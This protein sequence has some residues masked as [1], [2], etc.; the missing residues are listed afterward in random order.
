MSG[1]VKGGVSAA[2]TDTHTD[3]SGAVKTPSTNYGYR[4]SGKKSKLLLHCHR[5][6]GG[7][8]FAVTGQ[9][10]K[11]L[12]AL[13]RAGAAGVTALEV[14]TWAYRFAAYCFD[15]R[16]HGLDIETVRESHE[17]GWHGRHVLHTPVRLVVVNLSE[18]GHGD[19]G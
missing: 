17:G 14:S 3:V 19:L 5:T 9:T 18:A 4:P 16:K 11:A 7:P 6:D 10:A 2:A 12:M 8:S 13:H 15:L 1:P